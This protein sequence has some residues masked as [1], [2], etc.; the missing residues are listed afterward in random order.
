MSWFKPGAKT[1]K[2]SDELYKAKLDQLDKLGWGQRKENLK[3]LQLYDGNVNLVIQEFNKPYNQQ[4]NE[5]IEEKKDMN[6]DNEKDK[7]DNDD[8]SDG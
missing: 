8:S 4:K 1:K 6:M 3:L 7:S 2:S 5:I